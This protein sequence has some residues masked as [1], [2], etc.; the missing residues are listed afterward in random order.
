MEACRLREV[1]DQHRA[2][3]TGRQHRAAL[4]VDGKRS[5]RAYGHTCHGHVAVVHDP[6]RARA[7]LRARDI[8]EVRGRGLNLQ[9]RRALTDLEVDGN[10]VHVF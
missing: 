10:A 3:A 8:P 1:R 6:D 2:I 4:R 9:V 5:L 7:A